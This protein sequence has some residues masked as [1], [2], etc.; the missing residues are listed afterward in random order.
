MRIAAAVAASLVVGI[1]GASVAQAQGTQCSNPNA[2]GIARTGHGL[3]PNC[4]CLLSYH[5][6][7]ST[8][9]TDTKGGSGFPLVAAVFSRARAPRGGMVREGG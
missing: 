2:L 1:A 9:V 7:S 8:K 4:F 6:W 3:D 5:F